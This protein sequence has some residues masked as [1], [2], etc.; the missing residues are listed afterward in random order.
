ML[1][2]Q[3]AGDVGSMPTVPA[4]GM[5]GGVWGPQDYLQPTTPITRDEGLGDV[6]IAEAI[7]AQDRQDIFNQQF[8]YE[9]AKTQALRGIG[10]DTILPE[11]RPDI[12]QATT[13]DPATGLPIEAAACVA[14]LVPGA[15]PLYNQLSAAFFAT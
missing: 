7:A 2:G 4:G 13:L 8:D 14:A 5:E 3:G 11:A 10:P 1:S 9:D 6:G 15:A 12:E